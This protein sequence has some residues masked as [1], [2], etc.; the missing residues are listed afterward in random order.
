VV[1]GTLAISVHLMKI[2]LHAAFGV[3]FLVLGVVAL[4]H[5][6]FALPGKKDEV[7]IAN[8]KVLIETRRIISIP[9]L[10]SAIEIALGIGLIFF[11][12]RKPSR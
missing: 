12:S 10:A 8:Q 4:I 1:H 9:R 3:L 6:N 5:P 2:S 7:T 11:G